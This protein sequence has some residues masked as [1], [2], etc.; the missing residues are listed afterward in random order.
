[1]GFLVPH[2]DLSDLAGD[3]NELVVDGRGNA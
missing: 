1:V 3:W 2:A